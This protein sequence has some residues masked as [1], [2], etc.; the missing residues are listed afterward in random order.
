MKAS[1]FFICTLKEAPADAEI[2]S[3]KLMIRAGMVS[4]IAGGIYSYLPIG[5]R[6]IFKVK[7]II[8]KEMN[9]AGAI[10]LL[11][12]V[13]QPAKLW[14]ESGRWEHYGLE[15]L[16]L[17]DRKD[18]KFVIGP[19]HEE[20]ITDIVR[21]QIRSYKQMPI[22]FYQIQTKF[23]DEIRPRF[24]I[25]RSR[26]FIMKDAYSFDKDSEG[27]HKS[28]QKMFDTYLRI[29]SRLGLEFRAVAAN[30]GLIG[31]D[32]SHEFHVISDTGEDIIA[33][34]PTSDFAANIET[35]EAIPL[36]TSRIM[37]TEQ[38]RKVSTPGR[39]KCREVADLL[40]IPLHRIIKSIVLAIDNEAAE[41]AIWL[42]MIR[43]DHDL[44]KTKL[45]KLSILNNYRF[46]TKKEIIEWFGAS[47]GY[48]GPIGAKK[49][50]N[51]IADRTVANTSDFIVG[52]NDN[53]YHI[54]GVN[55]GRDLPEPIV[56]DIRN[57]KKGDPSPDGKGE[58]NICRG[59]EVGHVFKLGTKYSEIMNATFIDELGRMQPIHMGCYGIGV[60]RIL[61]AAIEQNFDDKGIVWPESIAPFEVVL[62]PIGYNYSAVVRN[63][64]DQLYITLTN[65]GIDIILDD[66]CERPGVMFSDWELIGIPHRIVIGERWLKDKKI[67]YQSRRENET[68]LLP[69]DR[70]AAAII[71]HIRMGRN[72]S[73]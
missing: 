59:I 34:C 70:T 3:H 13:V 40:N 20:V 69:I 45:L 44:N 32:F 14:Q 52:A 42:L 48:I 16:R 64:A 68:L 22:N 57:I 4:R 50:I 26:E 61:A 37:P 33:Y 10:E 47:P 31:G 36:V 6:S 11:M 66:R 58:I 72:R 28:Y 1:C 25:M 63:T 27:L 71:D 56:A 5:L 62:C 41:P 23:R 12:P 17:Q 38:M 15:L 65:A 54:V 24:G 29:F 53:G 7:A 73:R 46:A 55:W 49:T 35:A 51:V 19:T 43:G 30:N 67:E 8:R 21:A 60:T 39:M 2:I 9:L 18:N